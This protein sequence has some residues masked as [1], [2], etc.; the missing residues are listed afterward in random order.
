MGGRTIDTIVTYLELRQPARVHAPPPSRHKM[1]L[2]LAQRPTVHFYRYLYDTVGKGYHWVDR[3]KLSDEELGKAIW[4]D[5]VDVFVAYVDGTPAGYFE[6]G[7][8]S[9][10]EIWL[11]YFGVIADFHGL[12]I[13]KWLLGEAIAEAFSRQPEVMRVETCTLDSPRALPLYQR[14]GFVPYKRVEKK[15]ELIA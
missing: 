9:D 12:G 15:L 13:G 10:K 2:M 14:F 4:A 5:G 6:L 7:Q 11:E 8:R 1:A 3:K